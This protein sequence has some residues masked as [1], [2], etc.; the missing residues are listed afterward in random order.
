MINYEGMIKR[1][2]FANGW[3]ISTIK[4]A[5]ERELICHIEY[6]L[7]MRTDKVDKDYYYKF[8]KECEGL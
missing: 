7:D 4:G 1:I 2:C 5:I 6:M 8:V 3:P